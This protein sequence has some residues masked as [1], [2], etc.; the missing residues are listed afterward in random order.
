MAAD[1]NRHSVMIK[2]DLANILHLRLFRPV[3]LYA[4]AAALQVVTFMARPVIRAGRAIH[5]N[6]FDPAISR[7]SQ[8]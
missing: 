5:S 3:C 6:W 8:H 4:R 1:R 7:H 2:L